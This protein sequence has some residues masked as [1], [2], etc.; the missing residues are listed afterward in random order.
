MTDKMIKN[1]SAMLSKM[2]KK[3]L[4]E[5]LEKAK[6]ILKTKDK[7]ALKKMLDNEKV[8]KLV[9]QDTAKIK[10]A[11]DKLNLDKINTQEIDK[12]ISNFEKNNRR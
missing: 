6:E 10:S 2:P 12:Q 11:I 3:E 9:G 4:N 1:L 8:A 5:N 7:D